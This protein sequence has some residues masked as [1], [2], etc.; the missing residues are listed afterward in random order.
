MSACLK[1]K[2]FRLAAHQVQKVW[3]V[4]IRRTG[5]VEKASQTKKPELDVKDAKLFHREG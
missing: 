2:C 5:V 4:L 3:S 1:V